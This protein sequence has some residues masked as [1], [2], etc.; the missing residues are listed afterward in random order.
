MIAA[1]DDFDLKICA[2]ADQKTGPDGIVSLKDRF[3]E[4]RE[5]Y[6]NK[7]GASINHPRIE[8]L[9]RSSFEIERQILHFASIESAESVNSRVRMMTESLADYGITAT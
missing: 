4:L 9:I 3:T 8:Y 1:S 5:R 7:S 2:Y 6:G